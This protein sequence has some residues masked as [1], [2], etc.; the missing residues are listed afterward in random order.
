MADSELVRRA[1]RGEADAVAE[2]L[3]CVRPGV[4]R[5]CWA[6]LG[7]L[8]HSPVSP[9][10]VAQEVCL[11]VFEALPRY[12]DRGLPF[13]G[14]VFRIAANK[15]ADAFRAARVTATQPIETLPEPVD[16]HWDPERRAVHA[17]LSRRVLRLLSD[18]PGTQREIVVL[19]VAAGLSAEEVGSVLGM[20]PAAVRMAQS[21]ALAR[22]R[23]Q[24]RDQERSDEV[25]A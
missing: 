23:E 24:A 1:A 9:D 8:R 25:V 4:V 6:H 18:L 15:V 21:R 5:Y 17:E 16:D 14:F 20:T 3:A 22:L 13:T 19:R 12:R 2:L 11:A 7:S 10:D